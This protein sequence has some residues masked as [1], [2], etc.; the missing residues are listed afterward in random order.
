MTIAVECLVRRRNVLGEG[1]IWDERDGRLHWLDIRSRRLES[2][3]PRSGEFR[4]L[5]LDVT[6]T[7][8]AAR[9]GGGLLV[10][11]AGRLGVLEGE[12]YEERV[13]IPD[14]PA[15]NRTNDGNVGADG[16]FWFGTMD[17]AESDASGS[18]YS[19]EAD[20]TLR[21]HLTG[22]LVPN[23]LVTDPTGRKLYVAD[24][25]RGALKAYAIEA[26]GALSEPVSQTSTVAEKCY[27]DG[28]AVDEEGFLWNAQWD[29]WRV[30]RY[31]PDLTVDRIIPVPVARPTSCAFGGPDRRT[32]YV[33][34]AT[35]GLAPQAL[36]DQ[37]LAG[38]VLALKTGVR[39]ADVPLFAG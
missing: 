16:R 28:G 3:D 24:S 36:E 27:P 11:S 31:A 12:R 4:C 8:I 7:A 25:A 30:V 34:S 13:G 17:D 2:V 9:S 19:L 32:L 33:T 22:F 23:T 10:A 6:A 20:W 15:G 14:E 38:S 21:R 18:V 5:E 35:T 29:G 26:D 39:G 37:P 1:P